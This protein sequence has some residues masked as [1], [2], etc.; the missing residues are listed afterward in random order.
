M[1]NFLQ[2]S[3]AALAFC[4]FGIVAEAGE[5][6][7]LLPYDPPPAHH[8]DAAVS[9]GT[10]ANRPALTLASFANDY[11][12][13]DDPL[14]PPIPAKGSVRTIEVGCVFSGFLPISRKLL[15]PVPCRE[16]TLYEYTNGF[17]TKRAPKRLMIAANGKDV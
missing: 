15:V 10:E 12:V 4:G 8:T 13:D 2:L 11:A 3:C 6:I 1:M 14:A 7:S 5:P 16:Q 9:D 17:V